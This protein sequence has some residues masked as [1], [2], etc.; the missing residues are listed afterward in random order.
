ME[1]GER[2][3]SVLVDRAVGGSSLVDGQLELMLHRF[4]SHIT[5]LSIV[6]DIRKYKVFLIINLCITLSVLTETKCFQLCRRMLHDDIRGVGEILNETV[7]VQNKCEGLTVSIRIP[8]SHH[9]HH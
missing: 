6:H 8:T 5:S 3:L 7:C 2:E 9:H 4:Q 1:D